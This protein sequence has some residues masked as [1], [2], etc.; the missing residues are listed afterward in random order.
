MKEK[1]IL[2]ALEGTNSRVPVWLMRQAGRHLP[3]YLALKEKYTFL[4]LCKNP[5]VAVEASLQPLRRYDMD[6]VICFSDILVPLEAMGMKLDF[7]PGPVF[8][9]PI[10]SI[11]QFRSLE[12]PPIKQNIPH[13]LE[14]LE[15]L[16]E[17]LKG[18]NKTL[19]GFTGAPY[20]LASYAIE[21]KTS[22]HF[23][24][25]KSWSYRAPHELL[26]ILDGLAD[27]T[28]RYIEAQYEAGAELVQMFDTWAGQLSLEDYRRFA[29]PGTKKII[30]NSRSKGIPITLYINGGY[31]LLP[32]MIEAKPDVISV[33]WRRSI[34]DYL[35]Q[36]PE[37]ICVQGNLDPAFL[38]AS[39]EEVRTE[40]K[41]ILAASKGRK[42]ILN[43]G[44]GLLPTTPIESVKAFV[45]T[46]LEA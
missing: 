26:E 11:E 45:E 14:T 25:I 1:L 9:N 3:E 12:L 19:L 22:K 40:T 4:E 34:S 6:G 23:E 43:L 35:E 17:K 2:Q 46:A 42:F 29:L 39:P 37:E 13:I 10:Q 32:A 16:K 31:H 5:D 44:H 21:G 18:T 7:N 15:K 33:D 28:A 36:I 38:F 27:L 30:D 8:E 20:T 41:K 24:A